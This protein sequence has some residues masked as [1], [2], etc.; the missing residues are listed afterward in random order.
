MCTRA[1]TVSCPSCPYR[2]A[3]GS[4][5]IA[6]TPMRRRLLVAVVIG[7]TFA[8]ILLTGP[9]AHA[10]P[11]PR[12]PIPNPNATAN[13]SSPAYMHGW[14]NAQHL[15]AV[16]RD[17]GWTPPEWVALLGGAHSMCLDNAQTA[18]ISA[19]PLSG[20]GPLVNYDVDQ[21][22]QG[23]MKAVQLQLQSN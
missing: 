8:T 3:F 12:F 4:D 9:S 11:D 5:C 19:Q 10:E 18:Y 6:A 13:T 21:D 14:M 16:A 7:G 2:Y 20:N 15:F 17:G 23:C 22:Y 1:G